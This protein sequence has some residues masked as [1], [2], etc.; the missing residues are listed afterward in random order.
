MDIGFG[1]TSNGGNGS[2]AYPTIVESALLIVDPTNAGTFS[3]AW[4]TLAQPALPVGIT[5][6]AARVRTSTA[7]GNKVSN[8]STEIS[9][10]VPAEVPAPP[11]FGVA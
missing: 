7:A 11:G 5:F 9:W 2:F 1:P 10:T 4:S 6:I 8:W 3:F